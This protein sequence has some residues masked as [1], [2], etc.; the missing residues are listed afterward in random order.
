MTETSTCAYCGEPR[1]DGKHNKVGPE[2]AA[3]FVHERCQ[4]S[5]QVRNLQAACGRSE[6]EA[7]KEVASWAAPTSS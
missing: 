6:S 2:E 3:A 7:R 4:E 5:Y 1:D